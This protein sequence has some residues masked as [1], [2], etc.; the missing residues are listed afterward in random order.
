MDDT[1]GNSCLYCL[2]MIS[3]IGL[4]V[5]GFGT[6]AAGI[7]VAASLN[8]ADW[9]SMSFIGLGFLTVLV[10]TLGCK[11]RRS[12]KG[13][14]CYLFLTLCIFVTQLGFTLGIIFYSD[15]QSMLGENNANAVRYSLLAACLIILACFMLGWWYRNSLKIARTSFQYSDFESI[16]KSK[17]NQPEAKPKIQPK[18]QELKEKY[19]KKA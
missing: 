5:V 16:Q 19:R 1:K 7:Y 9:Y 18:Y 14:L 4:M 6:I 10:F 8:Q 3:N 13:T 12:M 15:F 11:S 2:F 17:S